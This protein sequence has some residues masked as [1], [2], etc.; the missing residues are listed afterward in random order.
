MGRYYLG[1]PGLTT[2]SNVRYE[3]SRASLLGCTSGAGNLHAVRRGEGGFPG[4]V[5]GAQVLDR[6]EVYCTSVFNVHQL[7]P[8]CFETRELRLAGDME[9]K[10]PANRMQ[11]LTIKLE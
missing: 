6:G 8:Q 5:W 9:R 10:E 3:R 4:M 7:G 1:A 2:R 11:A